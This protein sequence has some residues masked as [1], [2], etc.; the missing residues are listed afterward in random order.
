MRSPYLVIQTEFDYFVSFPIRILLPKHR[1]AVPVKVLAEF[2]C[3]SAIRNT[4]VLLTWSEVTV[5]S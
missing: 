5:V 2:F 1:C 3:K 4:K